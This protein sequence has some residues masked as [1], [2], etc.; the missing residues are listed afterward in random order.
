MTESSL[1]TRLVTVN[2]IVTDSKGHHVRDLSRDQFSIYDNKVKQQIAHF[3]TESPV[4]IGIVCEIQENASE[5]TRA[6]LAAIKQ[7][8][9]SLR[10]EDDFFFMAFS[11]DGH[12]ITDFIPSPAQ[13][14]D[15]LQFVKPGGPSSL[16]DSVYLVAERLKKSPNLKKALLVI[17]DGRDIRSAHSYN[18]L[19]NRLRTFDAQ[20][21]AIG[22]ADSNRDQL[23]AYRRWFFE[24][25]TRQ[26]GRRSFLVDADAAIG[27]A[28]LAEMSRVSGGAAYF[29]EAENEP[30]LAAI[31]T[32]IALELRQQFTLAFYSHAEINTWHKLKV[33]VGR[34]DVKLS[35]R[36]GY[37]VTDN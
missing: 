3:S 2:V 15:H 19:R 13:V 5:K 8:T 26:G 31:C 11:E 20:I 37:R 23:T 34:P 33:Q 35:Y 7:F 1:A 9:T 36:E 10:T 30:E 12:L 6:I 17:S 4:S 24:D 18:K 22:I 25:M 21:Y 32:Q 29:P 27:R 14:L 16:Y 28:V